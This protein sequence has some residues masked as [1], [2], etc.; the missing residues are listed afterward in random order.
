M[1]ETFRNAWKVPELR[2][3]LLFTFLIIVIYRIGG[4][5]PVPYLDPVALNDWFEGSKNSGDFF[6]YLN[7][8]SGGNFSKATL[9][10][11]S[12]G[13][14]INAQ[15][16]IQ[17][18]TYALPPL[19][20]LSKEGME[21][22]KTLNKITKYTA[23]GIALF[24]GWAYY[25]TLMNVNGQQIV[26]YSGHTFERYFTEVIIIFCFVAGASLTIWL[27]D[28][29]NEKGI[30]NG[31]SMLLFAGIIARGPEAVL[32]LFELMKTGEVKNMVLVPIIIVVF[33]LMI[34]FIIFMNNAERRIPIQYAKR[35]VGRKQYGGQ[36][37]YI[38]IKIAMSGVLPIIFAMSFMSIPQTLKLFTGEPKAGTFY[39]GLL[40][41]FEYTHPFYACLYFVLIIAFNY[42][43]VS[44]S[45]NPIEI[46]NNLRQNNGGVPGIRPGK[47]TSDYLQKILGKIT[48]VGAVFLGIIA[49]F[50]IIF[51]AITKMNIAMGGTSI[52]IVV[53]VALETARTMESQMMMRHH[54]GFLK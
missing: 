28:R 4:T 15:I 18:L 44:M 3:K 37:T 30:G 19:E 26:M 41:W 12:V 10:A 16:I 6:S 49:I 11:L 13:P 20:R 46:A 40:K 1:I 33:I 24:Q 9:M 14:Y 54:S 31:V 42:F 29:I 51:T 5:I 43:Y 38:P 2:R 47:P 53:S 36:S 32:G 52:L 22:R 21:G 7:V 23:L 17:L 45:Y 25:R 8:L 35:V 48:L 34:A 27:G 50:P 39:A